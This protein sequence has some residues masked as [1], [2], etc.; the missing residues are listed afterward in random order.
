MSAHAP[1]LLFICTGNICRSPIAEVIAIHHGDEVGAPV[2]ARSA[3]TLGIEEAPANPHM[4]AVARE[5]GM[6]LAGH[7]SQPITDELVKW[8]DYVLCME[9]SHM[10][11]MR[12]FHPDVGERLLLLGNFG[13]MMDIPDPHGSWF[14]KSYRKSRDDIQRCVHR[15]VDGLA[16]K[17]AR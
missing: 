1:R 13:G 10:A 7:R 17:R 6:D 8:A 9:M 16:A 11:H 5:G 15:F 4:V 14:R 3:G 2:Q 12:E